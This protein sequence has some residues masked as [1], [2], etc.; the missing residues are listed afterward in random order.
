MRAQ[1]EIAD[2]LPWPFGARPRTEKLDGIAIRLRPLPVSLEH[3]V[4]PPAE[5][6]FLLF[7][8]DQPALERRGSA[9][10]ALHRFVPAKLPLVESEAVDRI[11]VRGAADLV[12]S[13]NPGLEENPHRLALAG[14]GLDGEPLEHAMQF[15]GKLAA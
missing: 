6:F 4:K 3:F 10:G 11:N 2:G 5:I 7:F 13:E 8:R 1:Q 12:M 15:G 14:S 9:G